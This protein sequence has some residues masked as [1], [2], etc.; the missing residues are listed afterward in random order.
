MAIFSQ[1]IIQQLLEENYVAGVTTKEQTLRH[2]DNLN[3]ENE[4]SLSFEWEVVLLNVLSKVGT[5]IHEKTFGRKNPDVYFIT[6]TE[7]T[8]SFI[9]DIVTVSDEGHQ[10]ENPEDWQLSKTVN[11]FKN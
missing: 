7:P 8:E 1:E 5:V 4:Q 11:P 2:I 6:R 9:A 3:A 10:A